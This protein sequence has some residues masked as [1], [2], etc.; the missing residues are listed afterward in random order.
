[1]QM[2]VV[3]QSHVQ[4]SAPASLSKAPGPQT[5]LRISVLTLDLSARMQQ[6]NTALRAL[7]ELG[8]AAR[9]LDLHPPGE[10]QSCVDLGALTRQQSDL[11][12]RMADA[13]T[14]DT[15]RQCYSASIYDVRLV[16]GIA[17]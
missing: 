12:L 10:R 7:R 6:V 16:W 1:M 17:L 15:E 4:T 14:Q 8:I 9:G 13:S 11:V 2:T 5:A 3:S